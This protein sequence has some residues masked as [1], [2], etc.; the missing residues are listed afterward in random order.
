MGLKT[1][2][3]ALPVAEVQHAQD[4]GYSTIKSST[5]NLVNID[6]IDSKMLRSLESEGLV[7]LVEQFFDELVVFRHDLPGDGQDH[8]WRFHGLGVVGDLDPSLGTSLVARVLTM[9]C[10]AM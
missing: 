8:L 7:Q 9:F 10:T 6:S 3:H 2:R 1:E 5:E 4:K